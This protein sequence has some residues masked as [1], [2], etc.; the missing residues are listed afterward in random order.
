MGVSQRWSSKTFSSKVN[1]ALAMRVGVGLTGDDYREVRHSGILNCCAH[2]DGDE[3]H[4]EAY[5]EDTA[6]V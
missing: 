4:I 6:L 2:N 5:I 1:F 3:G